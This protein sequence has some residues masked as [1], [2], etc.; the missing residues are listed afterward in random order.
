MIV[1]RFEVLR[2]AYAESLED[3]GCKCYR[4]ETPA[5]AVKLL[6]ADPN[7]GVV[8][9]EVHWPNLNVDEFISELRQIR[10]EL[11]IVTTGVVK[12]G[13]RP[14]LYGA[15]LFIGKPWSIDLLIESLSKL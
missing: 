9:L 1:D 6:E 4:A 12:L 8:I 13:L 3:S 10:P 5:L 11:K 14:D 2:R 7:I 15:D